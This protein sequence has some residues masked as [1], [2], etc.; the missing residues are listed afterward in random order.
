MRGL[1]HEPN[2]GIACTRSEADIKG[3]SDVRL[4]G[5]SATFTGYSLQ[6]KSIVAVLCTQDPQEWAR[7]TGIRSR[8]DSKTEPAQVVR[9]LAYSHELQARASGVAV[10]RWVKHATECQ[11]NNPDRT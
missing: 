2:P 8:K 1:R 4:A 3:N 11:M 9:R 6:I 5:V 10:F 7:R